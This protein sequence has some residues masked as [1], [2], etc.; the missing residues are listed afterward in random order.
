MSKKDVDSMLMNKNIFILIFAIVAVGCTKGSVTGSGTSASTGSLTVTLVYPSSEGESW[1]PIQSSSRYFIKGLSVSIKGTCSRGI[2]T[3]KVGESGSGGPFYSET[4]T[5]L[6]DGSFTWNKTFTGPLD[7][8][9][10]LTAVAFDIADLAIASSDVS[11]DVHIDNVA[12]AAVVVTTPASSPFTY[13]GASSTYAVSGTCSADTVK[14]TGPGADETPSGTSWSYNVTVID[15]ASTNYTFY[16][17]DLAGNQSSGTLQTIEWSPTIS[18]L[19]S[20]IVSGGLTTHGGSGFTLEG[21]N[22][23]RDGANVH[24]GSSFNLDFGFNYLTN[25]ARQ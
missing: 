14:I 19:T 16:A 9:K 1:T 7:V 18:L 17:F 20:N 23:S 3:I 12:P 13:T 11:V 4:A 5:C 21:S 6:N 8:D 10:T 22:E 24:G 15:G 25:S 2:A